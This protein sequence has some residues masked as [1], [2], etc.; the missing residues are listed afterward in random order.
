VNRS[1]R[2]IAALG[3]LAVPALAQSQSITGSIAAS[4]DI[5]TVF[6]FGVP[7]ALNFGSITP[8][9]AASA[10][11]SIQL[12]R[13]VGVIYS[14]PDGA[15]TGKLSGPGPAITPT[16]T[17]GVGSTTAAIVSAFSSCNGTSSVLTLPTPTGLVNEFVIF[18]GSLTAAQTNT[19]PGT[20]SGTIRVT[21]TPN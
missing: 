11:G 4:A 21:A 15:N 19:V 12:S 18:N 16:Y 9:T 17:C 14:L 5:A 20:Y 8:N 10:S 3:M 13:N 1:L 7:T 6:T 2:L